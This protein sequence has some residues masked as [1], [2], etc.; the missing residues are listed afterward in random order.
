MDL[1]KE[2]WTWPVRSSSAAGILSAKL[3][4]LRYELKRWGKSLSA[5]K[6]LILKCNQ[7]ILILDQLEDERELSRPEF[8]FRNIV[9]EHLKALMQSQSDYWKKRC[10]IRWIKLGGE[11]TKFFH[12]KATERYRHN[13]IADIMDDDGNTL[14]THSEKANAF[15]HSFKNRMGVC[16]ATTPMDLGAVIQRVDNLDSLV[17][18]FSDEEIDK[19]V[20][21]MKPDRAP[22]PD[23]FNG[24]FLKKCWDIVRADFINLCHD[25]HCGKASLQSINGSFITLVP[26]KHSPET[27]NDFRP[28]SLTNTCLK[29]LT[30]LAANRMQSEIKR[31]VH[32]NQYGFIQ[33]RTIQDCLAWSFE[34][35]RG[36]RQGDPQSPLLFVQGADLLQTLVNIAYREGIL[37]API[38]V[39]SDFPIIQYADDTIIILPAEKVQLA[40]FK[41]ILDQYAAFTGLKFL[42]PLYLLAP[43]GGEMCSA[44][45]TSTELSLNVPLEMM[46]FIFPYPHKLMEKCCS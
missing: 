42:M 3:K 45:W 37:V 13:V 10:T 36:V 27:I 28:I 26:K 20:Q 41:N 33:Q 15:L 46:D 11:N 12:S 21:H 23:G 19:I 24:L 18:P 35:L 9:K 34:F 4:N 8:N 39:E 32:A 30:K 31:T 6:Q 29:F 14:S 22:G 17:T 1:V 40:A 44:W 16:R 5:I 7:A 38:P 43:S 25:F 2:V